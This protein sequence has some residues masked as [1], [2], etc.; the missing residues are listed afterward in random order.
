MSASLVGSEMCIRDRHC[1]VP[2]K[3]AKSRGG[4]AS[5]N[6]S[7]VAR[8]ARQLAGF[9]PRKCVPLV[10]LQHSLRRTGRFAVVG[11]YDERGCPV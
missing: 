5:G 1:S 8:L 10:P 2:T 11:G 4:P 3:A 9:W 6:D 7:A